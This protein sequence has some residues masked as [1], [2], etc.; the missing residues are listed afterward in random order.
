MKVIKIISFFLSLFV[1]IMSFFGPL[2]ICKNQTIPAYFVLFCTE[3]NV[4]KLILFGGYLLLLGGIGLFFF[5][6]KL[7]KFKSATTLMFFVAGFIFAFA[8][9]LSSLILN[10]DENLVYLGASGIILSI[11]SF[12]NFMLVYFYERKKII[13]T[14]YDIVE[15][16]M[17]VSIAVVL[18]TFVKI[19]L[20]ATGGSIN[21][22]MVPLIVLALR[23]DASK[24]F[25]ATGLIYGLA[26]CLTDG[27]GLIYLP[28][29]YVL[30]FGSV[31]FVSLFRHLII[32]DKKINI[33]S[34]IYLLISLI[35]VFVL[36]TLASTISSMVYYGY[37]FI[38]G[39]IYNVTYI[40]PSLAACFI[41]LVILIK[42]LSIIFKRQHRI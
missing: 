22:A 15:M 28:F 5:I 30:G 36:R 24:T 6:E 7:P 41:L 27:Y 23:H 4:F 39:V 9:P 14:I 12:V 31:A 18:D 8:S 34:F 2:V 16:A 29:D 33:L 32:N 38:E 42:P 19:P 11:I 25:V 13:Y 20:G 10:V 26:T 17:L 1:V 37:S 21:V 40:G 3:F 35:G